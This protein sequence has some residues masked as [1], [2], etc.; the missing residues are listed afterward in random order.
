MG[1]SNGRRTFLNA[2]DDV[3]FRFAAAEADNRATIANG[4]PLSD[5]C[6][7]FCRLRFERVPGKVV[8]KVSEGDSVADDDAEGSEDVSVC[9]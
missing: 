9:G 5:D 3:W 7:K 4:S 6:L 8:I 1:T 2:T